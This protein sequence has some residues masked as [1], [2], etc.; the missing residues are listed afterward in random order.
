LGLIHLGY[1]SG[2]GYVLPLRLCTR[3]RIKSGFIFYISF[4]H[5]RTCSNDNWSIHI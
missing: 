2:A 1:V 3:K 5:F 4:R